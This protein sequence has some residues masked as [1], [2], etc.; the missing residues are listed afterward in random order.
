MKHKRMITKV[1]DKTPPKIT[2]GFH[3]TV[4]S[5]GNNNFVKTYNEQNIKV[6]KH[7]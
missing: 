5:D 6:Q 7:K 4:C 1:I 3:N 2:V